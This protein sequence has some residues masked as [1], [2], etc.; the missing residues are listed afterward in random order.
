[1]VQS[2]QSG[3]LSLAADRESAARQRAT[4]GPLL[5]H[6]PHHTFTQLLPHRPKTRVGVFSGGPSGRLSRRGR[7]RSINTPGSRGCAYKTA[8]GRHEWPN[9]D[10]LNESGFELLHGPVMVDMVKQVRYSTK[11]DVIPNLYSFVANRPPGRLDAS[12]LFWLEILE[13]ATSTGG[14]DFHCHLV[15]ETSPIQGDP[16]SGSGNRNGQSMCIW[17]CNSYG[18][19]IPSGPPSTILTFTPPN[20]PCPV[21][22]DCNG[23]PAIPTPSNPFLDPPNPYE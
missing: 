4:F 18:D 3:F 20:K 22:K 15:S 23:K 17:R 9:R 12:G 14:N 8:S 21:P 11:Y 13:P 1:M 19:E 16:T 2:C 6:R 7:G 10:P 5:D